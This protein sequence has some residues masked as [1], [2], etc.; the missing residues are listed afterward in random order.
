MG[1]ANSQE[2]T[3]PVN[4]WTLIRRDHVHSNQ[5]SKVSPGNNTK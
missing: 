1:G 5:S 2:N 3:L 4:N